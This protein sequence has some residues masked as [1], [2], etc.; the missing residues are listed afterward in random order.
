VHVCD[1]NEDAVHALKQSD[2][3]ITS[4]ICDVSDRSSVRNSLALSPF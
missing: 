3:P 4:T 1:H 2:P